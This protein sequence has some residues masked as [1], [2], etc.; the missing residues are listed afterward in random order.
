MSFESILDL[1]LGLLQLLVIA[2]GV[3]IGGKGLGTW[4]SQLVG[5][6]DHDLARRLLISLLRVRDA[7]QVVRHPLIWSG[8]MESAIKAKGLE[9]KA[10]KEQESNRFSTTTGRSAAYSVRWERL[11]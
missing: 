3:V 10:K 9:E 8:E 7:I 4:R 5:K 6:G 2:A 11:A 1:V